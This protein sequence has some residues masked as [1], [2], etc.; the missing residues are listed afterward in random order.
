VIHTWQTDGSALIGY[1]IMQEQMTGVYLD[2]YA[3]A[4]QYENAGFADDVRVR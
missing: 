2:A 3:V 4:V 1:P